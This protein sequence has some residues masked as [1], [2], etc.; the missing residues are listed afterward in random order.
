MYIHKYV[1][2]N[3]AVFI[4]TYNKQKE[5]KKELKKCNDLSCYR[6]MLLLRRIKNWRSRMKM[7]TNRTE[8]T[9]CEI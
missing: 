7:L 9:N 1:K 5:R 2:S 4:E 8:K 6:R 3:V